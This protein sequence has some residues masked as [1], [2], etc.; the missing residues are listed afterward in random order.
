M[1]ISGRE[2]QYI[3]FFV[4]SRLYDDGAIPPEEID[5]YAEIYSAPGAL[6]A[7]LEMY[8]ALPV[9]RDLNL[10]ALSRDGKLDLPVAA[11]GSFLTSTTE[12]LERTL[13]EIATGGEAV[14]VERS[15][16]WIPQEQP[17]VLVAVLRRLTTGGTDP[18]VNQRLPPSA[19]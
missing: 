16:H 14:L 7:A 3:D 2:R 17:G 8:R 1:L 6:R 4:R 5:R 9:D 12:V 18:A 13:G 10:A 11:V 19:P 15:G